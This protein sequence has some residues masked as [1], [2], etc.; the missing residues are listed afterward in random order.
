[1]RSLFLH[2]AALLGVIACSLFPLPASGTQNGTSPA[3]EEAIVNSSDQGKGD[4][5]PSSG[6][7]FDP[8]RTQP[9]RLAFFMDSPSEA[10]G[11][12]FTPAVLDWVAKRDANAAM[13]FRSFTTA[14]VRSLTVQTNMSNNGILV[15]LELPEG[16]LEGLAAGKV[17]RQSLAEAMGQELADGVVAAL[18]ADADLPVTANVQAGVHQLQR[19]VF[20]GVQ[21]AHL[22]IGAT[23]LLVSMGKKKLQSAKSLVDLPEP[24]PAIWMRSDCNVHYRPAGQENFVGKN[25]QSVVTVKRTEDGWLYDSRS[26]LSDILPAMGNLE[27]IDFTAIPLFSDS[28]PL[29]SVALSGSILKA[30][31]TIYIK[32]LDKSLMSEALDGMPLAQGVLE[33]AALVLGGI[34]A[35]LLG[36]EAPGVQAAFNLREDTATA[37]YDM[38]KESLPAQWQEKSA[39]GWNSVS[40]SDTV[41]PG[42]APIPAS[43]L[44]ARKGGTL[45]V[46]LMRFESLSTPADGS[47]LA[48]QDQPASGVYNIDFQALWQEIRRLMGNGTVLRKM[49]R[50]DVIGAE[51]VDD[52]LSKEFP[53][54]A[55]LLHQGTD[56]GKV[57]GHLR[58]TAGET[59]FLPTLL[60]ILDK[61]F[62]AN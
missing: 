52:L 13:I 56:A 58:E 49:S 23:P 59:G 5:M 54:T 28:M 31:D 6:V 41:T 51:L 48:Y 9:S 17:N 18:G 39:E 57:E 30:L 4:A 50:V 21:D 62:P 60:P 27:P 32:G 10:L 55:L 1:M 20:I 40:T 37:M 11:V 16:N 3:P 14:R 26:N 24:K 44:L 29:L 12:L 42:G 25:L 61:I 8:D 7:V 45:V 53:V 15:C 34:K 35:D 33:Q 43:M 36:M 22:L 38:L 46:G 19:D 2:L 47:A